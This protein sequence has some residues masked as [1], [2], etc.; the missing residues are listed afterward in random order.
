MVLGVPVARHAREVRGEPT[1]G[2]MTRMCA[3]VC[4]VLGVPVA[5]HVREVRGESAS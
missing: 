4:M 5:R 1:S 2:I 3:C